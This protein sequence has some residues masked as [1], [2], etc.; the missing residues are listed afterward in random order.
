MTQPTLDTILADIKRLEVLKAEEMR[1]GLRCPEGG[2]H[3]WAY[4]G[5]AAH[6]YR[7]T[8]CGVEISK[9]DLQEA[10]K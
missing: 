10:T 8:Q 1:K 5:T 3:A 4:R 9:A 7:C 6:S 2:Q